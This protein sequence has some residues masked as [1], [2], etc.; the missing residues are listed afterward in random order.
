MI[1][2]STFSPNVHVMI[3][4]PMHQAVMSANTALMLL[5]AQTQFHVRGWLMT[6]QMGW[7]THQIH[8]ARNLIA[9]KF[10]ESEATDLFFIDDDIS[11]DPSY[12]VRMMEH[13][14]D[15][16]CGLYVQ[17]NGKGHFVIEPTYDADRNPVPLK[18][19]RETGLVQHTGCGAGFMR[20]KRH[21]LE[22]FLKLIQENYPESWYEE[23]VLP[24][25][26]IWPFF[27]CQHVD[28]KTVHEDI[29]F[30][31]MFAHFGGKSWADVDLRL[32]HSGV[33]DFT[34]CPGEMFQEYET[35][36]S[37]RAA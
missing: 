20:I 3:G 26:K 12:I 15:V 6:V 36:G 21:A 35:A 27:E 5:D 24:G 18:R 28:N 1:A 13:P 10:L 16:V 17:K 19:N 8:T 11:G 32:N 33:R 4:M 34:G 2:E 29:W 22:R 7:G 31:K 9:K 37:V 30:H 25:E 14:V 23:P